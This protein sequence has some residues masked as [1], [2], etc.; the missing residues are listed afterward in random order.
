M[1]YVSL[2]PDR[3]CSKVPVVARYIVYS[4]LLSERLTDGSM[5]E[6]RLNAG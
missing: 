3:E 6:R 1:R 4:F 5:V 2:E